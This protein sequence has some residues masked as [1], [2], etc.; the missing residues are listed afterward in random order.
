MNKSSQ[1][2]VDTKIILGDRCNLLDKLSSCVIF[3]LTHEITKATGVIIKD[4]SFMQDKLFN[5]LFT[6]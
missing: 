2:W 3:L 5:F 4:K 1:N 6:N